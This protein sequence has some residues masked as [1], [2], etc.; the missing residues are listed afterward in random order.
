MPRLDASLRR[1]FAPVFGKA[2][3]RRQ[4]VGKVHLPSPQADKLAR[5]LYRT[6]RVQGWVF[7]SDLLGR[8]HDSRAACA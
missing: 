7:C 3:I 2:K 4:R 6:V 1:V 8:L 5:D